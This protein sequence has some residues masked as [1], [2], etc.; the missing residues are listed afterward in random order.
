MENH[1]LTP[2]LSP[3]FDLDEHSR[4]VIR[5]VH[6]KELA[7]AL[8]LPTDDPRDP[9]R[10]KRVEYTWDEMW[11]QPDVIQN[12]LLREKQ[13]I[14]EAAQYL[15]RRPIDRIVMAGCGD[16][17]ASMIGVRMAYEK[18]LGVQT[19]PIQALDFAYYYNSYIN[20]RTLVI[21]LSSSGATTRT[22]EA[23][24][25]GRKKG[26]QSLTLSN[27]SGSP[28][29]V[30]A[31]QGL[32]IHAERKGWPTQSS[33]AA[34][35]TLLQFLIEYARAK[36]LD[37]TE[38]NR[39]QSTLDQIPD[40]MKAT[41]TTTNELIQQIAQ[42]EHER[43]F[44]LF[45]GSGPC[46]A[47]ALFGAAKVKEC[48]PDRSLAIHM[49]EFHHYNS[50][51]AGD[52]LFIIA[53][54]GYS[55]PRAIDTARESKRWGGQIY[56]VVTGKNSA[57][58]DFSDVVIRLPVIDEEF[59]ALVYTMPVQLFGYHVAMEKFKQAEIEIRKIRGFH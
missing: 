54:D 34:M 14:S 45:A 17:L 28:L 58:N 47:A 50:L 11:A 53:P 46:Y 5:S 36:G 12:T 42:K 13:A 51:K 56:S 41:L 18:L 39:Y 24:M 8:A 26:A 1:P 43:N 37:T 52:P 25:I 32:L 23:M 22:V 10:R 16:S 35:A 9:K 48:T 40:M 33:T 29:M 55:L 59:S 21:T 27:T 44:Y 15:A 2:I 57:L 20:T 3:E 49:E 7:K 31:D 38:I 6:E 30:E 19:E 4:Q